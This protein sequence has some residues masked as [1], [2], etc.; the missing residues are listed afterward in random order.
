MAP[1]P[2]WSLRKNRKDTEAFYVL[3][4]GV[5]EGLVNSLMGVVEAYFCDGH[6][7][8]PDR[9]ESLERVV[10]RSLPFERSDLLNVFYNDADLLLDAVDHV[11]G[12][13]PRPVAW[14]PVN[15]PHQTAQMIKGFFGDARSVYDV[16]RVDGDE[17]ELCYRQPTEVTALVEQVT[18]DRSRAADHLRRAWS[19]GFSRGADLNAACIEAVKA[20][21]AA[22]KPAVSPNNAKA[23]LGTMIAAMRDKPSKW[24]TDLD[25][26][27]SDALETVIG[28]IEMVW[29]GHARHGNPDEPIDVS[30]ERCEMILHT[31]ALLVHWFGSGRVSRA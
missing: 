26:A 24:L 18:S 17:Y 12:N 2:P 22:A 4:D 31:A 16:L 27:G 28:M 14:E 23:T 8:I 20:I 7:V 10:D 6:H 13:L 15:A 19:S 25:T 21:E 9:R 3:Q 11:L 29:K 5:P 30:K 1:K